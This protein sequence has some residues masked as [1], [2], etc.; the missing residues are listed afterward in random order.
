LIDIQFSYRSNKMKQRQVSNLSANRRFVVCIVLVYVL[1]TGIPVTLSAQKINSGSSSKKPV[2]GKTVNKPDKTGRVIRG[3]KGDGSDDQIEG[4]TFQLEPGITETVEQI[5]ERERNT[6]KKPFD[7][8]FVEKRPEVQEYL[9]K[10]IQPPWAL[11]KPG[12]AFEQTEQSMFLPQTLGTSIAGPGRTSD[13]IASIPPDSVGDVGPTQVL[14]HANGRV[15]VYDKLTGALGGLDVVDTTFW[16]SVRNGV[17]ISDPRVEYDRLSGRWILTMINVS[18]TLNR[19][20]IAVSSGP[21][22]TNT[23]S[24]TFFFITTA[25]QFLDYETLG[26]DNLAVYIGGNIFT[27]SSGT[28]ASTRGY[29]IPKAGLLAGAPVATVFNNLVLGAGAGPLTPQGVS[30][31]DPAATEGYFIGPDNVAFSL[32]QIRRVSTPGGVPTISANISVATATT[33]YPLGGFTGIGVPYQGLLLGRSLDDLDDRLFQAQIT[34]DNI[35]GVSRLWTSHNIEVGTTG[36]ASTAGNRNG[37]RWYEIGTLTGTPAI[38]QTGTL[39]DSAATDPNSYWIPSI[40]VSGQGHAAI[41]ASSAGNLRFPSLYAAGRLRTDA[42]NSTQAPSLVQ[43]SATTYNLEGAN[44]K[45][46]WGDYSKTSVD[47]CD[48]QTFWHVGEYSDAANSWRMQAVQLRAAA[49]PATATP[50]PASAGFALPNMN[51]TVT[52][53]SVAGTEFYDNPAG[54]TC[55]AA[56]NTTG[57]GTCHIAAAITASPR[58]GSPMSPAVALT[59]NSVTFN[60]PTQVTVNISTVG[61][62]PGVHTIQLRNPDGQSTSFNFTVLTVSA[63]NVSVSGRVVTANGSGIRNVRVTLTGQNGF[64]RTAITGSFGYF[65]FNDVPSSETYVL[66]ANSKRY[67][68]EPRTISVTD[69]LTDVDLIALP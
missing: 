53:V 60:T 57:T 8:N 18:A 26:V 64:V 62:T 67:T 69:E 42:L 55:N 61:A 63:A 29:V 20:L 1:L 36:V 66:N 44:T 54:F 32:L 46:R 5:M 59:I 22:I 28:F 31:D 51:V 21:T 25:T 58:P 30:N 49:P 16:T 33:T 56:C 45:Q 40:A 3:K 2:A 10:K 34:R 27:T 4:I 48:N 65:R 52:G 68:F 7:P 14:M 9:P 38:V 12:A 35:T 37:S 23:A 19:I 15:K 6:P 13:A 50:S 24:F 11:E 41:G 17:G 43:T 39:F 47:P